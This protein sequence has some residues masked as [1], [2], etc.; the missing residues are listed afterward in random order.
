MKANVLM[1]HLPRWLPINKKTLNKKSHR[2]TFGGP[3]TF[4]LNMC[5][6]KYAG[7]FAL[8]LVFGIIA[9]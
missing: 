3:Y 2:K 6:F 1:E 4:K 8:P 5:Q 9:H 7:I